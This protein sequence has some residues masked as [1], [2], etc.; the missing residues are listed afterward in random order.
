MYLNPTVCTKNNNTTASLLDTKV[1]EEFWPFLNYYFPLV[2]K[3]KLK[4]K[5]NFMNYFHIVHVFGLVF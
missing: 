1:K 2:K 3:R 5:K 4:K